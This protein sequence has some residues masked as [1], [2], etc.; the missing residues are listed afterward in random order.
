MSITKPIIVGCLLWAILFFQCSVKKDKVTIDFNNFNEGIK[1]KKDGVL[2]GNVLAPSSLNTTHTYSLSFKLEY[3]NNDTILSIVGQCFNFNDKP[4]RY[5]LGVNIQ[6]HHF[7]GVGEYNILTNSSKA[8]FDFS[9]DYD[10]IYCDHNPPNSFYN[11]V[12]GY[13]R[14]EQFDWTSKKGRG[15]FYFALENQASSGYTKY[16]TDGYF[17]FENLSR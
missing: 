13:V 8:N 9:N 3:T 6:V 14:V 16:I 15:I 5:V 17:V 7:V 1:F 10:C 11:A 2:Y 4:G 12:N